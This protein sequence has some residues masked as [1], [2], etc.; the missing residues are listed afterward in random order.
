MRGPRTATTAA[1]PAN[2]PAPGYTSVSSQACVRLHCGIGGEQCA[3]SRDSCVVCGFWCST[4][5][6]DSAVLLVGH[7][8][9]SSLGPVLCSRCQRLFCNVYVGAAVHHVSASAS[10]IVHRRLARAVRVRRQATTH[11][12]TSELTSNQTQKRPTLKRGN[13][14]TEVLV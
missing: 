14:L 11:A 8:M 12:P 3:V 13:A 9:L 10:T 7:F 1:T 4:V 2:A 5:L 6:R